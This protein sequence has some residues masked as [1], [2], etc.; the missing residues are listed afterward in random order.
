[1]LFI[2]LN[3]IYEPFKVYRYVRTTVRVYTSYIFYLCGNYELKLHLLT[4]TFTSLPLS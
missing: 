2:L 4:L 1:M 3:A